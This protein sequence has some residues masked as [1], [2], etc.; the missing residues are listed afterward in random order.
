M[1]YP[2]ATWLPSPNFRS[3]RRAALTHVVLHTTELDEAGSV[4]ALTDPLRPSRVSAHY[5]VTPSGAVYQLVSDDDEAWHAGDANPWSIG[6]E[7]VGQS[8]DPRTWS[9]PVVAGLGALVGWLSATYG[10]PLEYRADE[11]QPVLSRGFVAHGALQPADRYDPGP[12]FPWGEVRAASGELEAPG[13]AS[14][15]EFLGVAAIV[16]GAW[17]AWELLR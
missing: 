3:G 13:G 4:A 6:V 16:V 12:W 10:I 14:P 9:P 7:V 8:D 1:A 11:S 17:I 5:L 15:I 2:G